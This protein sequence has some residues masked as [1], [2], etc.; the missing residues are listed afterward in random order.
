MYEDTLQAGKST[1]FLIICGQ[2]FYSSSITYIKVDSECLC[3]GWKDANI[4]VFSTSYRRTP[5]VKLRVNKSLQAESAIRR[6]LGCRISIDR[7]PLWRRR[8]HMS[9]NL[10]IMLTPRFDFSGSRIHSDIHK[11]RAFVSNST[12]LTSTN[13]QN[14]PQY[15]M[16]GAHSPSRSRSL[17][18]M[19]DCC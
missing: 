17:L 15:P 14:T 3:D 12:Y 19:E 6:A 9:S 16:P 18:M 13:Y 11:M 4:T 10:S 7:G 5:Q 1:A 2:I 8:K